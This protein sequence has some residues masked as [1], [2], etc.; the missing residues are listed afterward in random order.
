[1]RPSFVLSLL[2]FSLFLT[3]THGIRLEKGS[4][5]VIQHKQHGEENNLLNRNNGAG[6]E[7][8]PC[9]DEQC[10]T[11][12]KRFSRVS[13]KLRN[14]L[15]HIHEDYSGPRHHRPSHH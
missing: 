9:K 7:G 3:K 14:R 5:D 8:I 15:P 4:Y 11:L 10:R 2:L 12:K 1:M 13:S 6:I